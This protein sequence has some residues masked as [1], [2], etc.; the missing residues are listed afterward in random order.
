MAFE[1]YLFVDGIQGDSTSTTPAKIEPKPANSAPIEIKTYGLGIEMPMVENRSGT[2]AAT[3]G[4]ATFEDFETEKTL[5]VS[6]GSLLFFCLS[7]KHINTAL[8]A[9][10]RTAGEDESA[11]KGS[12]YMKILYEHVVITEVAVKGG[13]DEMPSETLKFNYGK[14]S[15]YYYATDPKTGKTNTTP[16]EFIWDRVSNSGKKAG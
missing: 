10:Y 7:G 13:G 2:G 9:I 11:G 4:R 6:T 15:Y 1:A 16:A 12:L 3:V 8:V 14:V 5:D